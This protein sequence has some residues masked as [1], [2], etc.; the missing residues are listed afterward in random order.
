MR[1]YSEI[2]QVFLQ[3][4]PNSGVS[5]SIIDNETGLLVELNNPDDW[6]EKIEMLINDVDKMKK[7]GK[8]ANMFVKENFSW[9]KIALDFS[10]IVEKYL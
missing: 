2:I 6:I 3:L 4:I 8:N 5:E 10:K 1:D 7:M 9:E